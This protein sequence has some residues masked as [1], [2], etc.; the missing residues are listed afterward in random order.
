[1]SPSNVDS[2]MDQKFYDELTNSIESFLKMNDSKWNKQYFVYRE[3][4]GDKETNLTKLMTYSIDVYADRETWINFYNLM[5]FWFVGLSVSKK[6]DHY[7]NQ[8]TIS[9]TY[10]RIDRIVVIL[11]YVDEIGITYKYNITI[12]HNERKED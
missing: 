1:M 5:S 7:F 2:E 11:G 10:S 12:D 3:Y 4:K 9:N 6:K 8:C